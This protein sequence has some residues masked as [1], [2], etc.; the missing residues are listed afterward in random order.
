MVSPQVSMWVGLYEHRDADKSGFG[1][2]APRKL[3]NDG[4]AGT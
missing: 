1:K 3:G 4:I 2:A